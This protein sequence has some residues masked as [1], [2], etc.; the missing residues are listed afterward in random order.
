MT[1]HEKNLVNQAALGMMKPEDIERIIMQN[2]ELKASY[3]RTVKFYDELKAKYG[4]EEF[5]KIE[6]YE[7]N[8]ND[9][10]FD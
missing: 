2:P 8:N 1:D 7:P 10:D 5:K 4:E 3:E 6:F 9:W